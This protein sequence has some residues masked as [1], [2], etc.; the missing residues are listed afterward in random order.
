MNRKWMVWIVAP[1]LVTVLTGC[2][3]KKPKTPPRP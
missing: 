2:P 1:V 3:K